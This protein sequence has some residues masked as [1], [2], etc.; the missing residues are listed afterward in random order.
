MS[1][2]A[3]A[4]HAG[5]GRSR[6]AWPAAYRVRLLLGDVLCA[7]GASTA[8][9]AMR[10]SRQPDRFAVVVLLTPVAWVL[11]LHVLHGYQGR[12]LGQ[13]PRE[14]QGVVWAGGLL[15]GSTGLA[16][17]VFS[18]DLARGPVFLVVLLLVA[19][20]LILR[21][22][23]R[24]WLGRAREQGRY[25]Q[26]TVI[27][28]SA[29][30][31]TE[32]IRELRASPTNAFDLVGACVSGLKHTARDG[33]TLD[34]VPVAGKPRD[35][36]FVVD[37]HDADLVAVSGHPG[38][39]GKELRSLAWELE[40]RDVDLVICPGIFEVAGPRLS[41]RAEAGVSLLHL[42]RPVRTGARIFAKRA[43]D[44]ALALLLTTLALPFLLLVALAIRIDSPGPVLF[45]QKRIGQGGREFTIY[46]FRTMAVDAEA[47]LEAL[48]ASGHDVNSVLFKDR[49]DP[50]VTTV[51]RWLRRFSIDE[52]PQVL[53]V[54]LGE[55]SLV[56]PRPG[57]ASEV[58]QYEPDAM[59]RL[60]VRPGMTGLW[61]VSG[62][63][64]LSW[65]QT[66]RLDLWYVDNWSPMLDLQILVRT[67]RAVVGGRGAF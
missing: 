40:E 23:M 52:V 58:D 4:E 66:V 11:A 31:A 37:Y 3:G 61:Q 35:V 64:T 7:L 57:L 39:T 38:L 62:R 26:R 19:S 34:G 45:R 28:G 8:A 46:K 14:Y 2:V 49:A 6:L 59:R 1:D 55:M 16:A 17:Y 27:V 33:A 50:R 15:L 10:V 67:A 5:G 25:R 21:K 22:G 54:L 53:N 24:V 63:S 47:R 36:T 41:I 30:S 48:R 44:K 60:R 43:Q 32:L 56:G 42:E 9:A 29:R 13:G 12:H 65:E 18:M 51:G 20:S